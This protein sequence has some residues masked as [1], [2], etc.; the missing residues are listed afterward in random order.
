MPERG[1]T[2]GR[3]TGTVPAAS[4]QA[5]SLALFRIFE[6]SARERF[7]RATLNNRKA[8]AVVT[9]RALERRALQAFDDGRLVLEHL[10]GEPPAIGTPVDRI[11]ARSLTCR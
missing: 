2:F 6:A 5:A 7:M 11:C 9:P 1:V 3:A 4:R 10:A 8:D